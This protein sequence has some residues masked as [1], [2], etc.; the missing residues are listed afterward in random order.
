MIYKG[1]CRT[2]PA[3][4]G[5]LIIQLSKYHTLRIWLGTQFTQRYIYSADKT[6]SPEEVDAITTLC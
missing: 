2:A 5:L 1:D 4:L 6:F 3:T